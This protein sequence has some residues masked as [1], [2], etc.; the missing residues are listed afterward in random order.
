[1]KKMKQVIAL[2]LACLLTV[3]GLA[4]CGEKVTAEELL[5]AMK[6][7]WEEASAM[8]AKMEIDGT[9]SVSVSGIS[10]D[11]GIQLD[12]KIRNV[13]EKGS[14]L[15]MDLEVSAAGQ[16]QKLAMQVITLEDG[17][18]T[19][20]YLC[21]DGVWSYSGTEQI[22]KT[23]DQFSQLLNDKMEWTLE[24]DTEEVEDQEAYV[25]VATVSGT[26]LLSIVSDMAEISDEQLTQLADGVDFSK[27]NIDVVWFISKSDK[28]PLKMELDLGDSLT[29]LFEGTELDGTKMDL[30]VEIA[31]FDFEASKE[32]KVPDEALAAEN[33][34]EPATQTPESVPADPGSSATQSAEEDYERA[35]KEVNNTG[36]FT[37]LDT[38][39]GASMS[40]SVP[41][42]YSCSYASDTMVSLMD[43][44]YETDITYSMQGKGLYS[45]ED[46]IET[47][48][49]WVDY[50]KEDSA[51]YKDV[52]MS[53][54]QKETIGGKEVSYISISYVMFGNTKYQEY[55]VWLEGENAFGIVEI[56][57]TKTDA[58]AQD[59]IAPFVESL[60]IS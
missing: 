46:V 52:Q 37:V 57:T 30:S 48:T 19:K 50:M 20:A 54:V 17:D 6:A 55:Y 31:D 11:I 32:I 23:D 24:K 56:D 16:N 18:Q 15:D 38:Y 51:S 47:A 59:V 12:G 60:T 33:P 27:L 26:D 7:C 14:V 35:A 9:M 29:K 34:T 40:G 36:T 53:E 25:L 44:S 28:T 3:A 4:G 39:P 58:A 21:Q 41:S 49:G 22:A 5:D 8:S 1:M 2:F 45:E 13:R 43:D 42:G 10:M